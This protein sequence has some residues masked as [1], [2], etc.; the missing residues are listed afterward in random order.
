[1]EICATKLASQ[2]FDMRFRPQITP[3]LNCF[4]WRE[5][6]KM[7]VLQFY[8]ATMLFGRGPRSR[9]RARD[10]GVLG[11]QTH[12]AGGVASLSK[13]PHRNRRLAALER[14]GVVVGNP[15]RPGSRGTHLREGSQVCG[16]GYLGS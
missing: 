8:E 12:R 7:L 4:S 13:R 9:K 3:F 15:A 1:M 10:G 5:T 16:R 14:I 11:R 2:K 6:G